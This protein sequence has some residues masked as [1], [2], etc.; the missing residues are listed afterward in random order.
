[1]GF[2]MLNVCAEIVT[3]VRRNNCSLVASAT[4][5]PSSWLG[6]KR[7]GCCIAL[8]L[9]FVLGWLHWNQGGAAERRSGVQGWEGNTAVRVCAAVI[10]WCTDTLYSVFSSVGDTT[11]SSGNDRWICCNTG[12]LVFNKTTGSLAWKSVGPQGACAEYSPVPPR[13]MGLGCFPEGTAPQRGW[14]CPTARRLLCDLG[15][16]GVLY[17]RRESCSCQSGR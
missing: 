15:L 3:E 5:G 13:A 7:R 11:D 1:M 17:P 2:F 16:S 9:G 12:T 6:A 10:Q 4:S 8:F 14:Q